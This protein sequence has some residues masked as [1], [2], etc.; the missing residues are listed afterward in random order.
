MTAPQLIGTRLGTYDVQAL[1]GTGGMASVYRGF[2]HNLQRLIAIKV[3][4]PAAAALPGFA[5]RFQQ[6]ARLVASLR[7]PHIV[8]VYDFGEQDGHTYMVQ[9]FLPGPMLEERLRKLVA[10]Q[11]QLP[12]HEVIDI[13]KQLASA[14]DTAHAA[15]IIHRDVKPANALWNAS[16]ALVL[17]DFGIAKNTLSAAS[18]TQ[19]GLVMGTPDYLS[20]EQAQGLA[21]TPAS[22]I[23]ALGVVLYE[24]LTGTVPFDAITPMRVVMSHISA[25]PP[26]IRQR[27]PDLP[28]AVEAVVQQALAKEPTQRFGSAGE[29][30]QALE[31]AWPAAAVPAQGVPPGDIHSQPTSIWNAAPVAA[32]AA[33]ASFAPVSPA[34]PALPAAVPAA[35]MAQAR[36]P[37]LLPLLGALLLLLLVGGIVLAVRGSRSADERANVITATA[38]AA[39]PTATLAATPMA[40][41]APA[42]LLNATA[43]PTTPT[44]APVA[45]ADPVAQLRALFE[46]GAADGRADND[47]AT[48]LVQLDAVQQALAAGN[49]SAA[50]STLHAIQKQL[51]AGGRSGTIAPAFMRQALTG[52]DAIANSYQLTLPFSVTRR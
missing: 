4:S 32:P 35:P 8:Q 22:D 1:L 12:Q 11:L 3:L 48:L 20:P 41:E 39:Q 2:D 42:P 13:I 43:A 23:Y 17:T 44:A 15:G 31:Q 37:A 19:V 28:S 38:P 52:I 26:P 29:L 45:P 5:D 24:L 30:A 36:R 14:L 40:A 21:L 34:D 27:R 9:E 51:L 7:H 33:S 46:T 49:T 50:A 10:H 16:G 25:P 18:L 6:E 47:G